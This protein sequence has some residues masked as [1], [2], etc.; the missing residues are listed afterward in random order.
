MQKRIRIHQARQNAIWLSNS[1]LEYE[2]VKRI[3]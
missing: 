3:T 1:F 2:T